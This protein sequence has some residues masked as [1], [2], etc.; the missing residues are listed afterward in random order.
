[1]SAEPL[2]LVVDDEPSMRKVLAGILKQEN[3][4]CLAA[5]GGPEALDLLHRHDV[6]VVITDLRMPGMDGL[7]LLAR[8]HE[9][10]PTIE[11]ILITAYGTEDVAREALKRRAS[12]YIRKP[13]DR[14]EILFAVRKAVARRAAPETAPPDEA[15]MIGRSQK[16]KRVFELIEK[17]APTNSTVLV[18]GESGTGKELAARAIHA[19]SPRRDRPFVKVVCAALPETLLESEL[20][21]YEKGAFTGAVTAKPGRFE[22]AEG[23]T[24]FL[25]EIGDLTPATQV[26]LLRILQDRQF[27]RL[28]GTQ[29]QTADVRVLA[30]THRDLEAF[31]REGKFREDLFYRINV[32]PIS[33]PPLRDRM[34]DL[35]F[36]CEQ[37]LGRYRQIHGKEG[38]RLDP[39][40]LER[41]AGYAWPGNVRELQNVLERLVVLSGG[42]VITAEET[43]ACLP[44]GATAPA[45]GGLGSARAEAERHAI[46]RALRE[47]DGNR[48]R[49]AKL[50][51]VSRR[52]LHNKLNEYGIE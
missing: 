25:D 33:L 35:P 8:V 41:L 18:L 13:F 34:D 16:M 9:I 12:D 6:S 47:T 28:G 38:V 23:G 37:L 39:K 27:E 11:V 19:K 7:A 40:A 22:L 14:D 10:D 1:M 5:A 15:A 49:A 44:A 36:L 4:A 52:T 42:G 30:A 2:V 31:V 3:I 26:K 50:L 32:V 29:T 46:E 24:V 51:G 48:T 20:F 45:G 21:G 43:A 17:V